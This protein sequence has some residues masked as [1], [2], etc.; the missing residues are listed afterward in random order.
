MNKTI[1]STLKININKSFAEI[2]NFRI[3]V[4]IQIYDLKKWSFLWKPL[5]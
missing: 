3:F 5:G 4:A 2:I 1:N